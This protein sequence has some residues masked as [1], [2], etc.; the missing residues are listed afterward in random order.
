M[1]HYAEP[2]PTFPNNMLVKY[3]H[4]I[5]KNINTALEIEKKQN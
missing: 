1:F 4:S 2:F 3:N 5:G